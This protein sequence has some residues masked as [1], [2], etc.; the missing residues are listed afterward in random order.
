[1][2]PFRS[3]KSIPYIIVIAA[4]IIM[5]VMILSGEQHTRTYPILLF[6][7]AKLSLVFGVVELGLSYL[8]MYKEKEDTYRSISR[9]ISAF[10]MAMCFVLLIA[11]FE[12]S[13]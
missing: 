6:I 3:P 7:S 9:A 5:G 12:S 4:S 2:K 1:M 13:R 8:G 11:A 10:G